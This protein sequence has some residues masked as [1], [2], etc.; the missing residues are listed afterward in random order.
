VSLLEDVEC[1][2][3]KRRIE[4]QRRDEIAATTVVGTFTRHGAK[5]GAQAGTSTAASAYVQDEREDGVKEL[6]VI[7]KA[8]VSGTLEA[9][10]GSISV[11]GNKLAKVTVVS[12]GVGDVTEA[13]VNVAAAAQAC[14]I[15]FNIKVPRPIESA[16]SQ[17]NVPL[18]LDSVIYRLIE[19]VTE[20][21]TDLLPRIVETRVV[22]EATVQQIF[23]VS[24]KKEQVTVAGCRIVNG[25]IEK[26]KTVRVV[27]KGQ[28]VGQGTVI[29]M[30]HL[31]DEVNE[32][33]KGMECGLRF[34]SF[35]D[36]KEGDLIQ[37]YETDE[38]APTL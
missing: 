24:K 5:I 37:A 31:K 11:I 2:N 16:A 19:K 3:E 38:K 14:I 36:F 9:V 20:K 10:V 35:A 30:R 18:H 15:G 29:E 34:D 4:K 25:Q 28:T 33:R 23:S 13:D 12:S 8:D 26:H 22:G 1:I 32:V 21:V 6:K 17:S 7:V 27:R